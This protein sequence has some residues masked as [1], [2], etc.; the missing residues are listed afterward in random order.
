MNEPF[1]SGAFKHELI[2]RLEGVGNAA[3]YATAARES[4]AQ[5]CL[6]VTP[7][8]VGMVALPNFTCR[9][10]ILS[11]HR[12]DAFRAGSVVIGKGFMRTVVILGSFVQPS[13][14]SFSISL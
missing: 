9:L 6:M 11:C 7:Q 8:S 13:M 1:G 2:D 14:M 5:R 12:S 4:W 10:A 3:T